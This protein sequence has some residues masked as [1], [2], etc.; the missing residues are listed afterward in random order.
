[1]GGRGG[2][3]GVAWKKQLRAMAKE[4]KM[5]AV[6]VG[7]P[8]LRSAVFK[9]ID[10]LYP[11]PQTQARITDLGKRV[12]VQINGA[13]YVSSYPSGVSASEAEKRGVLKKL[14]YNAT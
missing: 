5:P 10:R 8:Q 14:L 1:M 4:G 11:M 13:V 2:G 9:E 12:H 7:G 6:I 3:G